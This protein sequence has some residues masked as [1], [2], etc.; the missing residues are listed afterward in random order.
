[1]DNTAR[2]SSVG[3][4]SS[5]AS[6]SSLLLGGGG[7]DGSVDGSSSA[8]GSGS[9]SLTSSIDRARTIRA[10]QHSQRPATTTSS[11]GGS[12]SVANPSRPK[13]W[14]KKQRT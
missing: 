8:N 2:P 9:G 10:F 7:G 11:E 12:L 1:M 4:L 6:A 5:S 13:R 14:N 3:S